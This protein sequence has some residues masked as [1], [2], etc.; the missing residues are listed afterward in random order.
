VQKIAR[1]PGD[2]VHR[3]RLVGETVKLKGPGER[4]KEISNKT[5]E[6]EERDFLDK[7]LV[8]GIP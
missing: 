8:K 3:G 7:P 5:T 1:G 2:N 4:Q 6:E